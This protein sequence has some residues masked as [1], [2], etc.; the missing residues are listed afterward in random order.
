MKQQVE[1]SPAGATT[2]APQNSIG[3]I[4]VHAQNRGDVAVVTSVTADSPAA[5]AG[6]QVG[7]IILTLNGSLIKGKDFETAIA[8]LRP[9]TQI[10]VN[11]ARG[12]SAHE[13]RVTVGSQN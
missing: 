2:N 10:S 1:K 12:S 9:G 13:V 4:G 7:D 11:Y 5:K 6:I 3:W 8:V